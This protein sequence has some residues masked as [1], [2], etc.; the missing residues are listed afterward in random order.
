MTIREHDYEPIPGLP[1]RLPAGEKLLWQGAPSWRVLARRAFHV[2]K[3]LAYFALLLAWQG[4]VGVYDGAPLETFVGAAIWLVPMALGATLILGA[5]AWANARSTVYSIT[6][7]R[8]VIRFGVALPM[9]INLPFKVV[10][11]V[12]LK[13]YPD[14]TGDLA[15]ELGGDDRVSYLHLWPHVRR[16]H[17]ANPQPMLR[18]IPDAAATGR[19][20]VMALELARRDAAPPPAAAMPSPPAAAHLAAAG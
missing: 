16:W 10:K 6:S 15:L 8:V 20:L 11:D 5:L 17:F 13:T 9:T 4:V 12:S 3:V 18:A 1:E 2:R 19:L 14:G 7:R